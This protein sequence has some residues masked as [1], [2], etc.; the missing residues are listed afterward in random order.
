MK[1]LFTFLAIALLTVS[2]F[3]QSPQLMSYQAV[4]RNSSNALVSN[5]AVGMRISI[6]QGSA[7]GTAVYVETQT[8]TT[9]ANGLATLQIGGG[10]AVAGAFSA[11]N[12][13]NGTYYIKTETD[14]TG[15]S[16]YTIAGTNQMLSV[17]YALFAANAGSLINNHYLGEEYLGGIIYYLY[18]GS[19]GQQHGLIV[20][21]TESDG[22]W[23]PTNLIN[24]PSWG[25]TT[26]AT[27]LYDGAFNTNLLPSDSP[28]KLDALAMGAGWYVPS[29]EE[30]DLL[31]KNKFHLHN[32]KVGGVTP[33]TNMLLSSTEFSY[34]KLFST[35]GLTDKRK[36]G[37]IRCIRSF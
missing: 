10:T 18:I 17:P 34:D 27:S 2:L 8:P 5:Q 29:I 13:S 15:G 21:K 1:R 23:T 30:L 20:S 32:T 28:L 33:I 24:N 19:D 6:L 9:N 14:P 16:N 7:T 11:I 35:S 36:V 37:K 31:I 25:S 12:W 26:G 22:T 4:V 3:A